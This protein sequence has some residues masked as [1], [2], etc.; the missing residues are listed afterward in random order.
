MGTTAAKKAWNIDQPVETPAQAAYLVA[1]EQVRL[2]SA[3]ERACQQLHREGYLTDKEYFVAREALRAADCAFD[4]A[5]V[6][7]ANEEV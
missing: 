1:L 2:A 3:R 6:A 4:A 5:V 7:L